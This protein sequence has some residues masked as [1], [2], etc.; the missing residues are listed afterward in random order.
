MTTVL[1]NTG[2][3]I[4]LGDVINTHLSFI[5][6]EI[7]PL[8][9]RIDRQIAVPDGNAIREALTESLD[10]DLVFVTGGLGPTSDDVTREAIAERFGLELEES[11]A[12]AGAIRQRLSSRGWK[13]TDRILRQA[14]VPK[15]ATILPNKHG[16]APGLYFSRKP[17]G[18]TPHLF[19]LPGPPRELQPMFVESVLPILREIASGEGSRECRNYRITGMGESLVEE[20]IGEKILAIS[21]I[22]LGYCSRPGEVDLRLIGDPAAVAQADAILQSVLKNSIFSLDKEEL[23]HVVVRLLTERNETVTTAES[24]TGGMLA[25]RL[26][27]IP[28]ASKV[29]PGGF[30]VY[31]NE[32]KMDALG[33]ASALIEKHGAVS[34]PVAAAMAE[35][36]RAR[37]RTTYALAT[38]GIAGPTGGSEKKPVGTVYIALAQNG[39]E[40]LVRHFNFASDRETFKQMATQ[41][42][43]NLLRERLL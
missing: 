29:F 43:L 30:V 11:E 4:L 19:A 17:D 26:T 5:A 41:A 36:A 8:G 12:I 22:E 31:A 6:R 28:G 38:T 25:N 13:L 32:T 40:T 20:A 10:A 42:A 3:E 34:K 24:C 33:L 18:T 27:N 21:G 14:L 37:N 35:A 16:T 23:E 9:L 2:T 1:I 39:A 7:F 15:G